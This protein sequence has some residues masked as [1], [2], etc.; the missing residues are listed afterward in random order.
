MLEGNLDERPQRQQSLIK[1]LNDRLKN[2]GNRPKE[3]SYSRS[4]QVSPKIGNLHLPPLSGSLQL[5]RGKF[6]PIK[7]VKKLTSFIEHRK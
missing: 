2:V 3:F 1:Q 4:S 6:T 7:D 5:S